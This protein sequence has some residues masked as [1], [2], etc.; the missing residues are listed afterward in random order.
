MLVFADTGSASYTFGDGL[1]YSSFEYHLVT[2]SEI[3]IDALALKQY[4]DAASRHHV[5]RR[6]TDLAKTNT[7]TTV[8]VRVTNTGNIAGAH[9]VLA[10]MSPPDPGV[11]R[12][13]SLCC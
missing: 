13:P 1:S 5:F 12:S 9:A 6:G 2:P 10:M 7:A 3:H 8:V 11:V 4:A